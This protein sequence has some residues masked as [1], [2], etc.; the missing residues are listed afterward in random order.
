MLH[1]SAFHLLAAP[2]VLIDHVSQLSTLRAGEHPRPLVVWEPAPQSCTPS[3]RDAHLEAA[4]LVDV[5]SPNHGELLSTFLPSTVTDGPTPDFGRSIIEDQ[6]LN[7]VQSGIGS[8]GQGLVIVRCAGHGCLVASRALPPRWFP[9]YHDQDSPKVVDATGA[10]NA[11]LG[12]FAVTLAES[13]E[14]IAEAVI[15]G[16]VASS[17]MIE[18]IGVPRLSTESRRE[19][20]NGEEFSARVGQF[21]ERLTAHTG[22][23]PEGWPS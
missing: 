1:S 10:G 6:A 16:A 22:S 9:A 21:T 18:Q 17:F 12:G 2:A 15:A 5:Y 14:N 7:I 4:R 23:V 19:T 3:L 11:F 8:D 20:W 13:R